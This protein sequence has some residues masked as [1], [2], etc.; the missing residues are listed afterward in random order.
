M[1]SKIEKKKCVFSHSFLFHIIIGIP[2]FSFWC[3]GEEGA[4]LMGEVIPYLFSNSYMKSYVG[5]LFANVSHFHPLSL[6]NH[7]TFYL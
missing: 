5:Y 1:S 2:L 7:N 6:I 4:A 3:G